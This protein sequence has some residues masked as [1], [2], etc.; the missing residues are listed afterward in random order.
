MTEAAID[1][2]IDD[3]PCHIC[4]HGEVE[5]ELRDVEGD[6]RQRGYCLACESWHEFVAEPSDL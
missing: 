5:H 4:K 2:P 6:L 3:Q 1:A